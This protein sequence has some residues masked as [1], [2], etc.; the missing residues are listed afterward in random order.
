MG[1]HNGEFTWWHVVDGVAYAV[2]DSAD[3]S[4]QIDEGLI[5]NVYGTIE[6][7]IIHGG[8]KATAFTRK[9]EA[10]YDTMAWLKTGAMVPAGQVTTTTITAQSEG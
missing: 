3:I 6:G 2:P 5:T 1:W 7:A 8:V 10:T 9:T 4:R